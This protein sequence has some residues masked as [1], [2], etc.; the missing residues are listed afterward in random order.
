MSQLPTNTPQVNQQEVNKV[1][2]DVIIDSPIGKGIRKFQ[3]GMNIASLLLIG[4]LAKKYWNKS[5]LWKIGLLVSGAYT[6]RNSYKLATT[7][8]PI[9]EVKKDFKLEPTTKPTT[10]PQSTSEVGNYVDYII[11]S[12]KVFKDARLGTFFA[13]FGDEKKGQY[14]S[15][16]RSARSGEY[17]V[18]KITKDG[19][20]FG[21]FQKK[22]NMD[23]FEFWDGAI[24]DIVLTKDVKGTYQNK[25]I[26]MT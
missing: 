4:F 25:Q 1:F 15:G 7:T 11:P 14:D 18:L 26:I 12:G 19:V 23:G 20:P 8:K 6:L 10:T 16:S 5:N 22:I 24:G 9:V 21:Q 17:K 3:I 2:S 13:S